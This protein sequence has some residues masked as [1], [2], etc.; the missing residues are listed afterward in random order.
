MAIALKHKSMAHA[1]RQMRRIILGTLSGNYAAG[2]QVTDLTTASNPLGIDG[3][4]QMANRL[5]ES[6]EVVNMPQGFLGNWIP[7]TNLTDGKLQIT[8]ISTGAEL[9]AGAYPAGLT[10]A[11]GIILEVVTKTLA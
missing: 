1:H 8:Q 5:P 9:V 2:G 4:K 11:D 3:A 10:G 6:V 7:G